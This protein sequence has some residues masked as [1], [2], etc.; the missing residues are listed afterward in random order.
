MLKDNKNSLPRSVDEDP[1]KKFNQ[2]ASIDRTKSS[3][4]LTTGGDTVE[5]HWDKKPSSHLK[6]CQS[7]LFFNLYDDDTAIMAPKSNIFFCPILKKRFVEEKA[8]QRVVPLRA[9]VS[10]AKKI[11][12]RVDHSRFH[13][14]YFQVSERCAGDRHS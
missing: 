13:D 11:G 1:L 8:S 7:D 12:S 2:K 6:K 9:R 10:K 4:G 3:A 14:R 5:I